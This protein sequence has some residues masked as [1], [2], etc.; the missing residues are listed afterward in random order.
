MKQPYKLSRN[1]KRYLDT[2]DGILKTMID[3]MTSAKLS[4]SISYNFIVQMI[5]HHRAAIEMSH[6]LL[7]YTINIPLQEIAEQI[8]REQTESIDQME[9]IMCHCKKRSNSRQELYTY[10]YRINQIMQM[11]FHNMKHAHTTNSID[12][13]FIRE[14]IPHHEGAIQMSET[15]LRHRICPELDPILRAIIRSQKEGVEQ[16]K[17]L[18]KQMEQNKKI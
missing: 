6:N 8:I 7:K 15:A 18:L 10:Q 11:M 3:E 9:Q 5:P 16:M 1:T 17:K 12:E 4:N 13:N 14:M 2:F